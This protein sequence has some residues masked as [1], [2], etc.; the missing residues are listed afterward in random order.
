MINPFS[1]F[2]CVTYPASSLLLNKPKTSTQ[3]I[4]IVYRLD[5][6]EW[7]GFLLLMPKLSIMFVSDI[8]VQHA[9][10]WAFS[11]LTFK[12]KYRYIGKGKKV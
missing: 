8:W 6:G 9:K 5:F 12:K 2:V 1:S 4:I 3:L 10:P 7:P 11:T